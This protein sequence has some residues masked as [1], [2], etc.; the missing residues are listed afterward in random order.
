MINFPVIILEMAVNAHNKLL[1]G[2]P[3]KGNKRRN[4]HKP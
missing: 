4:K 1:R 2:R 3:D